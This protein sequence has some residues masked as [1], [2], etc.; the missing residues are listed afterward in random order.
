MGL[1]LV[2]AGLAGEDDDKRKT[3]ATDETG[4]NGIGDLLLAGTE[5]DADGVPGEISRMVDEAGNTGGT[6][7]GHGKSL[8]HEINGETH[9][10]RSIIE[11][12]CLRCGAVR[13]D[14]ACAHGTGKR[15][16]PAPMSMYLLTPY[17]KIARSDKIES[18]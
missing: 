7:R 17:A 8:F 11:G 4:D 6:R 14:A 18:Q 2:L 5:G 13:R 10:P 9:M 1:G 12:S 3:E 16:L 15:K